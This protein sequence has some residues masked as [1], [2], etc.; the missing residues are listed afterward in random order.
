MLS[1]NQ[2]NGYEIA[3]LILNDKHT[4]FLKSMIK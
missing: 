1:Y 3:F 2:N 4:P